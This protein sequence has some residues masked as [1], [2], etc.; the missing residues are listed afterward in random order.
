MILTHMRAK[1]KDQWCVK[2]RALGADATALEQIDSLPKVAEY[3]E[4]NMWDDLAQD[5]S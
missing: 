2:L 4:N 1:T 5:A 3:I